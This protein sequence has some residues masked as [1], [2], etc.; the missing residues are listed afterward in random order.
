MTEFLTSLGIL[1][2]IFG[3]IKIGAAVILWLKRK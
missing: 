3:L 1:L 2:L